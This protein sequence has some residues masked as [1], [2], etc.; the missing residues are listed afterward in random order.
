MW[1]FWRYILLCS[2]AWTACLEWITVADPGGW[3][4]HCHIKF[5]DPLKMGTLSWNRDLSWCNVPPIVNYLGGI[6]LRNRLCAPRTFYRLK[7]RVPITLLL[8]QS[9]VPP[10]KSNVHLVC[11]LCGATYTS[12]Y[13]QEVIYFKVNCPGGSLYMPSYIFPCPVSYKCTWTLQKYLCS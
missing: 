7:G 1:L 11:C 6:L 10:L 8:L 3:G 4:G 2:V 5:G 13:V 12:K 9:K